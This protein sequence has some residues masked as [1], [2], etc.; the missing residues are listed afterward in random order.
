[1]KIDYRQEHLGL[2]EIF[3][4]TNRLR[5]TQALHEGQIL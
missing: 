1:M 2:A 4:R 5:F 3:R